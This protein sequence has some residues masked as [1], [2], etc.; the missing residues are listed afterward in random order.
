MGGRTGA[1]RVVGQAA[2]LAVLAVGTWWVFLGSDDERRVD[3]V[4]GSATGPYE[5][6]QVVGCVL[7]LVVLVVA[8]TLVGPG[9][10]AVVA[11]AVPFT[12]VWSW[13]ARAHDDSGLWVVGSGLV[14]LGTVAG[15]ALVAAVTRA[16]RRRRVHNG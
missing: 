3:P 13:W 14:L 1:V 7:V 2:L 8:G 5:V 12:A 6:P 16:L 15:G 9:W 4:S 10:V 11:V